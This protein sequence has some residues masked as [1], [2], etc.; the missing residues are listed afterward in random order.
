MRC[1]AWLLKVVNRLG[2]MT[3]T[4]IGK[5][6]LRLMIMVNRA[7]CLVSSTWATEKTVECLP[8]AKYYY[9]IPE[10]DRLWVSRGRSTEIRKTT[11]RT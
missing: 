10:Y 3:W 6:A 2:I 7:V 8:L 9:Y 4:A 1:F 5:F 11:Y